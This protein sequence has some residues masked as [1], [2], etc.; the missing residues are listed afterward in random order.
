[1]VGQDC[2]SRQPLTAVKVMPHPELYQQGYLVSNTYMVN[3]RIMVRQD[4]WEI[5]YEAASDVI[6]HILSKQREAA[7]DSIE[8]MTC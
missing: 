4:H 8:L 7:F 2:P 6:P 1:M 5:F 3:K